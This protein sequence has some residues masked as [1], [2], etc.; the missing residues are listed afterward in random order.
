M[1]EVG[2]VKERKEE[3]EEE[4]EEYMGTSQ[5]YNMARVT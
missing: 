5:K 2:S 1:M 4:E 3:E